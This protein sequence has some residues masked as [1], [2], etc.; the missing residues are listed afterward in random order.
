MPYILGGNTSIY[1][2]SITPTPT[3]DPDAQL[4]I[5]NAGITNSVEQN[6]LNTFVI[7]LKAAGLWTLIYF[8]H[9]YLGGTATTQRYNLKNPVDADAAFRLQFNGGWTHSSTGATPNGVNAWA[10]T[11]FD[12]SA[13]LNT[14]DF[15]SWGYYSRT[16]SAVASEY[17]MGSNSGFTQAACALIA[18]R[19]TNQRFAF[20]DF[21]TGTTFRTA[22]DALS[23][24]GRG[25]FIGNMDG[26]NMKLYVNGSIVAVNT[27][28]SVN[29]PLGTFAPTIGAIRAFSGGPVILGYT[30]KE[31]ALDFTATKLTDAQ[32]ATL[33]NLVQI[34]QTS[35]SRQV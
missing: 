25:F 20:M 26:P 6:A 29:T 17:V 3:F 12:P 35:L 33:S 9:V 30:N 11:F 27:S 1:L 28:A 8:M 5:T 10:D 16:D 34:F 14:T 18:R 19:N 32:V 15:A 22:S 2:G 24:D 7:G 23:T 13:N 4:F 21:P 31:C